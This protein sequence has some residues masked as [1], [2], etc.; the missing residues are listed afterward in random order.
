MTRVRRHWLDLVVVLLALQV[1]ISVAVDSG[2]E[3]SPWIAAPAMA[4]AVLMLLARRAAPFAAPA[5]LWVTVAAVSF[6]DG[7]LVPGSAGVYLA[8][9]GAAFLLGSLRDEAQARLGLAVVVVSV[10]V[11][12][13]NNPAADA[14]DAIS[15]AAIF[16]LAWFAGQVQRGRVLQAEAAEQRA[17]SA[18][19]EREAAA[20]LAVA[21]ER[22]RIARELHDVVAHALSVMVLQVGAV[23]H[24]LAARSPEDAEA[25][26]AVEQAGRSAL[27]EMRRLLGALRREGEEPELTPQPGLS[28]LDVLLEHVRAAGLPV[29][30]TVHGDPVALPEALDLSAYRIVQE[31]LTN[32][33][34]HA[35]ATQAEVIVTYEPAELRIVVRDVG[36]GLSKGEGTG[37]GLAGIGE[38]VKIY[39]GDMTAARANGGGFVLSTRLPLGE[40]GR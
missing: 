2:L 11:L 13:N 5:A 18:E 9:L 37:H 12:M 6:L 31:G 32:A 22:A 19:R 21:E 33:L 39:G 4:A 27:G 17:A 38:R 36:K 25:L 16:G 7:E 24:R 14:A 26:Q 34:K 3:L 20:R 1:A 10:V 23:R 30:L 40:A 8:G 28:H 35:Q 29:R 15:V